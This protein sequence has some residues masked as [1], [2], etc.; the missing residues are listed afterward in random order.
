M[1]DHDQSSQLFIL[2]TN[3][4]SQPIYIHLAQII[5]LA[6][7]K[8]EAMHVFNCKHLLF[9]DPKNADPLDY[10]QIGNLDHFFSSPFGETTRKLII[11]GKDNPIVVKMNKT[12]AN[13]ASF[14][15]VTFKKCHALL[16]VM[17]YQFLDHTNI[18]S[19]ATYGSQLNGTL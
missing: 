2:L 10:W 4:L 16:V 1:G 11:K 18:T 19:L 15:I 3:P 14:S 12:C 9:C 8:S 5:K 13:K 7:L 6:W 17:H